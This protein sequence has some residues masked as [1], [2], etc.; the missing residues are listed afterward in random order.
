MPILENF[1]ELMA[2]ANPAARA[3]VVRILDGL[4][5]AGELEVEDGW[6]YLE[7]G[8]ND[9]DER[10]KNAALG[11]KEMWDEEARFLT[12]GGKA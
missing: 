2:S 1:D 3:N 11:L 6:V 4:W 10:V 9:S 12:L 7:K 8:L 5:M